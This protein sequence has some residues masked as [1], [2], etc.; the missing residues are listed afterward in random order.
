M[1]K[2]S[3]ETELHEKFETPEYNIMIVAEKYQTGYDQPLL[4]TLYI[5]INVAN[6]E[7][8]LH[9]QTRLA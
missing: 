6:T 8:C 2:T 1:N 4:H 7:C 3:T 9:A 5:D